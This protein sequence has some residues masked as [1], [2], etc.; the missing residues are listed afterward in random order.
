MSNTCELD[1]SWKYCP[2]KISEQATMYTILNNQVV[3]ICE[4]YSDL[5]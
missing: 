5:K 3:Y 4:M 1:I 2:L